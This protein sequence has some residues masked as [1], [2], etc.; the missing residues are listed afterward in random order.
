MRFFNYTVTLTIIKNYFTVNFNSFIYSLVDFL[1]L[2]IRIVI[3]SD[4]KADRI[5]FVE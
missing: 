3:C 1:V 5:A 4:L 2:Y